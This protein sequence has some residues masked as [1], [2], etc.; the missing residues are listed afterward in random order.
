[1]VLV[2]FENKKPGTYAELV[3]IF[4]T[5]ELY[6]SC[7][8]SL[9]AEAAKRQMRVTEVVLDADLDVDT[10]SN[11][12]HLILAGKKAC[13]YYQLG[14]SYMIARSIKKGKADIFEISHLTDLHN[15]LENLRGYKDFVIISE[16][17]R[18]LIIK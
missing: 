4:R 15:L 12:K 2:Y 6:M 14:D 11:K 8:K 18:D 7:L 9:K 1:M 5:E 3:S 10:V 16:E 13:L 17:D